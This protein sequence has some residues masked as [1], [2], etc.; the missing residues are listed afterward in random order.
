MGCIISAGDFSRE[1]GK[2]DFDGVVGIGNLRDDTFHGWPQ[3]GKQACPA[4]KHC[5]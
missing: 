5:Q 1:E 3:G 2:G 4:T